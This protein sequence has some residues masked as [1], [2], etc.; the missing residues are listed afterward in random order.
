[1]SP[2]ASPPRK[3]VKTFLR[4]GGIKRGYRSDTKRKKYV[5]RHGANNRR[6]CYG[7]GWGTNWLGM[8]NS[9]LWYKGERLHTLHLGG[10]QGTAQESAGE[11]KTRKRREEKSKEEFCWW[12]DS[13]VYLEQ[14][15]R[16][17]EGRGRALHPPCMGRGKLLLSATFDQRKMLLE[18]GASTFCAGELVWGGSWPAAGPGSWSGEKRYKKS[19]NTNASRKGLHPC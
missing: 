12:E 17:L 10:N 8:K 3:T 19:F 2:N 14:H 9:I 18:S 13:L 11:R 16:K 4:E 6:R 15:L 1:M 5:K 7:R